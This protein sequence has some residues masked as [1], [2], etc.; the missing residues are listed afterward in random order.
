M[1]DDSGE[2]Y[3]LEVRDILEKTLMKESYY[4]KNIKRIEN[5]D[6]IKIHNL[7]IGYGH[8]VCIGE[9]DNNKS[10]VYALGLNEQGQC[11]I[12]PKI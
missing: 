2:L 7:A 12:N 5:L 3:T 10:D 11:G 9:K 6:V 8:I 4:K 1:V